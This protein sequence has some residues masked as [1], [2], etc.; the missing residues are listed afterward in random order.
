VAETAAKAAIPNENQQQQVGKARLVI[1]HACCSLWWRLRCETSHAALELPSCCGC[2]AC[3]Q[4]TSA[5]C[6]WMLRCSCLV[7]DLVQVLQDDGSLLSCA[8]N[9]VCAALVDAGV[10]LATT[11]GEWTPL[12][13]AHI[14]AT[15]PHALL[16]APVACNTYLSSVFCSCACRVRH[17]RGDRKGRPADRPRCSRAAGEHP[18]FHVSPSPGHRIPPAIYQTMCMH[19]R[20]SLRFEQAAVGHGG[21]CMSVY[22]IF[23]HA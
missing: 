13:V 4:Q 3:R 8:L 15:Y 9:A 18:G 6:V 20:M 22:I 10:P 19:A 12:P 21:R 2:C 16:T 17:L 14:Y 1:H 23:V 7:A 5:Q 11:F